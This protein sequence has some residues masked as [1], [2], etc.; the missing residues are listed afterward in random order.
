MSVID[1]IKFIPFPEDEYVREVSAKNKFI[2]HH[3]ASWDN[4]ENMF[5]WWD[6]DTQGRVATHF[7]INRDGSIIQGYSSKYWAYAVA[8]HNKHNNPKPPLGKYLTK[9]QDVSIN[10]SAIQVELMAWGGLKKVGNKYYAW[11]NDF[12]KVEIPESEVIKIN[13]RGYDYFHKYTKAQVDSCIELI[14]HFNKTIGIPM[15]YNPMM[16]IVTEEALRGDA[17]VW[18]HSSYRTDKSDAYPDPYLIDE[19]NKLVK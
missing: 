13:Y 4:A 7:G 17:G 5:G 9:A 6:E 2:I 11:P 19:L 12:S 14:K 15:K 1:R 16:F 10:A 8:V 3:S 18:S